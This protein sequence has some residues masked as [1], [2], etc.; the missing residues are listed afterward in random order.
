MLK[1]VDQSTF[2]AGSTQIL[3]GLYAGKDELKPLKV[4]AC[5]QLFYLFYSAKLLFVISVSK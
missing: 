3:K 4:K 5:G 1:E 2:V